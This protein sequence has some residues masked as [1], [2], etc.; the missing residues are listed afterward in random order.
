MANVGGVSAPSPAPPAGK[1]FSGTAF[2]GLVV[3]GAVLLG[4]AMWVA[5]SSWRAGSR[6]SECEARLRHLAKAAE[7]YHARF[8]AWPDATGSE[9]WPVILKADGPPIGRV[10]DV[11][12]CPVSGKA[13]R[14]PGQPRKEGELRAWLACCDPGIHGDDTLAINGAG[15]FEV[16]P[17]DDLRYLG[18]KP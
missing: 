6:R 14:G 1:G 10:F 2:L 8:K 13:Y 16:A 12:H 5:R 7:S 9:F 15:T 11:T 4:L 17:R 18:T 3:A